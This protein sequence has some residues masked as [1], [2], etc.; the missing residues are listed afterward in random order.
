MPTD[1]PFFASADWNGLDIHESAN[2]LSPGLALARHP[3]KR[4]ATVLT[5]GDEPR[6]DTLV[7]DPAAALRVTTEV[8]SFLLEP[9]AAVL[10][11][12]L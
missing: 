9:A 3:G 6:A 1:D 8:S 2:N 12:G 10:A 7:E 5:T 11:A 4:T